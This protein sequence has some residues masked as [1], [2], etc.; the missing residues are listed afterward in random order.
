MS[1]ICNDC[2]YSKTTEEFPTN[3][4]CTYD[5]AP[6]KECPFPKTIQ[7]LRTLG[8]VELEGAPFHAQFYVQDLCF[9]LQDYST[10]KPDLYAWQRIEGHPNSYH[11]VPLENIS[12]TQK[13][14]YQQILEL[15]KTDER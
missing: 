2:Q 4:I 5:V 10:D 3:N 6:D 11:K 12:Q 1:R 8:E 13:K 14:V 9:I 15:L 7:L